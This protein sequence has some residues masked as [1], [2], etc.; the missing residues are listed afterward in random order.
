MAVDGASASWLASIQTWKRRVKRAR[1]SRAPDRRYATAIETALREAGRGAELGGHGRSSLDL[2][3]AQEGL[4]GVDLK[5]LFRS[6][7]GGCCDGIGLGKLSKS[8]GV[9]AAVGVAA[10]GE[11]IVGIAHLAIR[12]L[13][14]HAQQSEGRFAGHCQPTQRSPP[15][16]VSAPH[17]PNLYFFSRKDQVFTPNLAAGDGAIGVDFFGRGG[18]YWWRRRCRNMGRPS[19]E[20]VAEEI[21][22]GMQGLLVVV[23]AVAHDVLGDV[24]PARVA[25]WQRDALAIAFG[26]R[27]G[28]ESEW[29]SVAMASRS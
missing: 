21:E 6:I 15:R 29:E 20:A 12:A 22:L 16:V 18:R 25:A 8:C 4:E 9:A 17:A 10:L 14:A 11:A 28:A 24:D 13:E 3:D 27:I 26:L 1:A 7:D 2:D 19:F 23:G 5:K